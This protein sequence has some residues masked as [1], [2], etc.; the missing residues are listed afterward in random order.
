MQ[1]SNRG[2]GQ[3]CIDPPSFLVLAGKL[4]F[5]QEGAA[6]A[7]G[8]VPFGKTHFVPGDR[9]STKAA[10]FNQLQPV[11]FVTCKAQ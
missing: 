5:W 11:H 6:L 10:I 4:G 3:A 2:T 1:L 7:S 9:I 8:H